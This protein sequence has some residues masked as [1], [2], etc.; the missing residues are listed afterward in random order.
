[1][2]LN[3]TVY[4]TVSHHLTSHTY[5]IMT[6]H[7]QQYI[8]NSYKEKNKF[9]QHKNIYR[10]SK[11][12]QHITHTNTNIDLYMYNCTYMYMFVACVRL[13]FHWIY[14]YQLI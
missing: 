2:Y 9:S 8:L 14:M 1:M 7:T 5:I 6:Q 4:D 3:T 11:K 12:H 13:T 10:I